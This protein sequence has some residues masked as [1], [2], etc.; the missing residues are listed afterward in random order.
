MKRLVFLALPLLM[1]SA[2]QPC[3]E[4][5]PREIIEKVRIYKLTEA[6]DLTDEQV[7][8]FFPR[9]KEM[10][11]TEQEFHKQRL[12]I[13]KELKDLIKAN[14]KEQEV[15]KILDKFQELQK[16]RMV[17]QM[18]EMKDL[19]SLLTPLQQAKFLIFQE[20]FERE[21]RDLIREVRGRR[22]QPPP[23]E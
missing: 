10:R 18:E 16:K 9:L 21:I 19:K 23:E 1:L 8:K 11:K 3:D 6:L 2:Q 12:E 7:T 4:K 5:D 14:A 20:D 13:L 17:A 15:V 22:P